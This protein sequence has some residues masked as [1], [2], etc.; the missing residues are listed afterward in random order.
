MELTIADYSRLIKAEEL[1]VMG[2]L[3]KL[4]KTDYYRYTLD[5]LKLCREINLKRIQRLLGHTE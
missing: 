2:E 4:N 3:I 1:D 5:V